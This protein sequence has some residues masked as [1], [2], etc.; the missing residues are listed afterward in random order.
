VT[1]PE[2]KVFLVRNCSCKAFNIW[3]PQVTQ[4]LRMFPDAEKCSKQDYSNPNTGAGRVNLGLT[5]RSYACVSSKAS[6][7]HN[8][9][10]SWQP[11]HLACTHFSLGSGGR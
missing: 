8:S 10:F 4:A 5:G 9:E 11:L 3:L 6:V 2:E 1:I 7:S